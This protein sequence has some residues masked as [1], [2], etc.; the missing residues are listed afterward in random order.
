MP[1]RRYRKRRSGARRMRRRSRAPSFRRSRRRTFGTRRRRGLK[2]RFGGRGKGFAIRLSSKRPIIRNKAVTF[3]ADD[4]LDFTIA[5]F[6]ADPANK[7]TANILVGSTL[8]CNKTRIDTWRVATAEQTALWTATPDTSNSNVRKY[9]SQNLST[10]LPQVTTGPLISTLP[11]YYRYYRILSTRF[12][13]MWNQGF[14]KF[15]DT[16]AAPWADYNPRAGAVYAFIW[17]MHDQDTGADSNLDLR[18]H[19]TLK[20]LRRQRYCVLKHIQTNPTNFIPGKLTFKL[21][22]SAAF[23]NNFFSQLMTTYKTDIATTYYTDILRYTVSSSTADGGRLWMVHGFITAD[24]SGWGL[25]SATVPD[26]FSQ[27][28]LLNYRVRVSQ[29]VLFQEPHS[30]DEIMPTIDSAV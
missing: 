11:T 14:C 12:T 1:L 25:D 21:R 4:T 24:D 7:T 22:H 5:A 28:M 23:G 13:M 3:F 30:S 17:F 10:V 29:K 26:D 16:G 18:S 8:F 15:S 2:R 20:K 9:F 27:T 6:A 19:L